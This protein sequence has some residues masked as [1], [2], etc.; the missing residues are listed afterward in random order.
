MLKRS[1][2]FRWCT[3]KAW[4][5]RSDDKN[6]SLEVQV[7]QDEATDSPI[8]VLQKEIKA[9]KGERTQANKKKKN[10][11]MRLKAIKRPWPLKH[12]FM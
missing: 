1:R 9:L 2:A 11:T 10:I 6:K 12:P 4:R 7:A 8:E 3:Q 5:C